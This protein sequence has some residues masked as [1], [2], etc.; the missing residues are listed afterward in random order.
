MKSLFCFSCGF[1]MEYNHAPPNFCA[2]CGE[3]QGSTAT[4]PKTSVPP[5]SLDED[6][7]NVE[8]LPDI[9]KLEFENEDNVAELPAGSQF[10]LGDLLGKPTESD[11]K[12]SKRR[13]LSE[14]IDDKK[15]V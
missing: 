2:K 3:A 7:T 13:D 5:N 12:G 14:F 1:K 9:Q 4:K 8:E 11:Y 10:T 6:E 15:G